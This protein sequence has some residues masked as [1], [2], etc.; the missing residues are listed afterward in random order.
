MFELTQNLLKCL[1]WENFLF[2]ISG[3]ITPVFTW[4]QGTEQVWVHIRALCGE[5][6]HSVSVLIE[7]K[8][9][10]SSV[11]THC[12]WA[13][14]RFVMI[15]MHYVLC[16]CVAEW[17][18]DIFFHILLSDDSWTLDVTSQAEMGALCCNI[19]FDESVWEA[20][21]WQLHMLEEHNKTKD[22]SLPELHM[23]QRSRK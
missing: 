1:Y 8:C 21:S 22:A 18:A 5:K 13:C 9:V 7:L 6:N 20:L 15:L 12:V 16:L 19:G 10:K 23:L 3:C 17:V 11:I 2:N 4:L 14:C